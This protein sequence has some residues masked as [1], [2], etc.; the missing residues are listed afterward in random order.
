MLL[1]RLSLR[2][3]VVG[4]LIVLGA[5]AL[6]SGGIGVWY[7]QQMETLFAAVVERDMAALQTQE[8]LLQALVKQKGFVSYYF[9]D[10]D[11]GWLVRL[12]EYRKAFTGHLERAEQLLRSDE[13]RK[14][15]QEIRSQY[16]TY[17]ET[18]DRVIALYQNG[19]REKGLELHR[20]VRNHFFQLLAL[21]ETY[22]QV[23]VGRIRALQ[24][25]SRTRAAAI[26]ILAVTTLFI[27]LILM[28]LFAFVLFM[29]ILGPIRR[30]A[31]EA[32]RFGGVKGAGDE[33]KALS[34]GVRGLMEDA[35][36]THSELEKSRVRLLQTEK[37][38]TVGK[39]AA[40]VAHSLR[41]PMTSIKMRLFSLERNLQIPPAQRED[42]EVVTEE[43]RH[44]DN[45]V[46][47]F[48]QYSRP[49]KLRMQKVSP[50]EIVDV[51]LQL[52]KHRFRSYGIELTL[53]RREPLPEILA[54]PDQLK[55]V[56]INLLVNAMEA[57]A[58]SSGRITIEET[59]EE[60]DPLGVVAVIRI[61]DSGPG[62]SA[63]IREKVFEPFFSTKEEGTGLGLSIAMRIVR[64][65]RGFLHMKS[66]EGEGTEFTVT[67]PC[68]ENPSWDPS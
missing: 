60:Q 65:H 30:L 33:V 38:A 45:I 7:T 9:M 18:R 63:S 32:E 15:L 39:L 53:L 57:M 49:A 47:N 4:L 58:G 36:H 16:Q 31:G 13:D 5:L 20:Q 62:I 27:A 19:E 44:M 42:L 41:N 50:S 66:G 35:D 61:R 17:V 68:R 11:P 51:T 26:R 6:G 52:L 21:C 37:M 12:D 24:R 8:G 14:A 25:E 1:K 22:E 64:Q 48:L 2:A 28:G 29:Q 34:R 46:Q 67:L 3:R 23:S 56:F 54:D 55:E 43:I 10:G 59:M 40:G